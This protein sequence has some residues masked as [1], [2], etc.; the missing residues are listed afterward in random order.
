GT[1]CNVQP[2]PQPIFNNLGIV[3]GALNILVD[4]TKQKNDLR[5]FRESEERFRIAADTAPVMIWMSGPDKLC[6]FF[7]KG[8]YEFTGSTIEKEMGDGWTQNIHPDDKDRC[9]TI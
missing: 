8:W 9:I 5:A 7:N 6:T 2:H 4:I 3:I 1:R